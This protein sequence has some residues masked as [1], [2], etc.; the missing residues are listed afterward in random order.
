MQ[1]IAVVPVLAA[2]V[3]DGNGTHHAKVLDQPGRLL[4]LPRLAQ[5]RDASSRV[6][7]SARDAG[8][9]GAAVRVGP[10][11]VIVIVAAAASAAGAAR[12]TVVTG[13]A[14]SRGRD[15][16]P[17]RIAVIADSFFRWTHSQTFEFAVDGGI[18]WADARGMRED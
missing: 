11:P 13:S 1:P 10:R 14:Q 18:G 9:V 6:G 17:I 12:E 5:F 8:G 4:A 16:Q 15:E 3:V 2:S 7:R